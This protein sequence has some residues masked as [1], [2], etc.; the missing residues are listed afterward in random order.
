[1]IYLQKL[2]K[3]FQKFKKIIM[4][5]NNRVQTITGKIE[6]R[7]K[8]RKIGDNYYIIGKD[9]FEIKGRWYKADSEKI[10]FDH[11]KKEWILRE[12]ITDGF[13]NG[14][15]DFKDGKPI[16]GY[17][18]RNKYKN[19]LCG[20]GG[21]G[22][23]L[24]QAMDA[25]MLLENGFVECVAEGVYYKRSELTASIIRDLQTPRNT[26]DNTRLAYN[27]E[28]DASFEEKKKLYENYP[29]QLSKE[30]R[31]Y[32]KFLGDT[33]FGIELETIRGY[34]PSHI[35]CRTGLIICRDGSLRD[36]DGTQGA[37]FVTVPMQGAKG[38]QNTVNICS[39]LSKRCALN[40]DCSLHIHLGNLPTSR[41]YLTAL[42][43][44]AV[45]IQD[46]LFTIFPYYK[47]NPE[48]IK[49]MNW[50]QKLKRMNI[51]AISDTSKDGYN[52]YVR[53]FYNKLFVF[54]SEGMYPD[55]RFN[56]KNKKHPHRAK[57]E[58]H[59]RYYW[60]NLMNV[61][62]SDRNTVEFRPHPGTLNPQKVVN[63]LFIVNAL[64]KYA[65]LHAGDI[66]KSSSKISLSNVLDYYKDNYKTDR[67]EFLS[68]YL[69][70]YCKERKNMFE[71]DFLKGDKIS[72]YDIEKD[73]DYEFKY[74]GVTH[75]F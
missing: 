45:K 47:T 64:V 21:P 40:L 25:E 63:W 73:F 61:I 67:A 38:L 36:T 54:L 58:R 50:N 27:I 7:S 18:S 29:T 49:R 11:E 5:N 15:V 65:S 14:I 30:V 60:M 1:V 70:A 55:S 31:A 24:Q 22:S 13:I 75:L 32:A 37:E 17:Y 41:L 19:C 12:Y 2:Q 20:F 62:F 44:L 57:W 46:E 39:E 4:P 66:I 8:C 16:G 26:R 51:R 53:G 56:R 23:S 72:L 10:V 33:T 43:T 48:G 59:N 6:Y 3:Y 69:N 9:V 52:N 34:M 28:E 74:K 35:Q 68:E 42:Y 71:K